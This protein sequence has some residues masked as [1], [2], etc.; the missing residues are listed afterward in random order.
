MTRGGN[1]GIWSSLE[2]FEV[3]RKKSFFIFEGIIIPL[4]YQVCGSIL[5]SVCL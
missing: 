3:V 5:F 1:G 4:A 2:L